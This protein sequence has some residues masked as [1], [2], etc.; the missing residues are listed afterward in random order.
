M[1]QAIKIKKLSDNNISD[2]ELLTKHGDDGKL[3]YCS[4]WHQKWSSM[5]EYHQIQRE[6]PERLRSCVIDRV[7]S[8][9]HVGVI[10][11]L[12]GEPCAW[13]SVGPLIDFFWAWKRVAQIGEDAKSIAGIM[14]FTVAPKFRGQKM[15]VKVLTALK[16]YGSEKGWTAIEA[17]PFSDEAIEK[18]G[19][20][21]KWT[22]L[23]KGY[24]SADFRK[25]GEHWLSSPEAKRFIYTLK[26][27]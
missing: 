6:N 26:L 23:S 13:V 11:Y 14:C 7:K 18:H 15:Q 8:N 20:A 25:S 9:F 17:Y 4:F 2:Y 12:D 21:L 19:A 22:G 3:C 16:K 27:S 10:A 1:S 5:D 24:E